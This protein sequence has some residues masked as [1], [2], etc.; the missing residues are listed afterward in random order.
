M[1][2]AVFFLIMLVDSFYAAEEVSS[3]TLGV[4]RFGTRLSFYVY[5]DVR[6]NGYANTS[7]LLPNP[8]RPGGKA[9]RSRKSKKAN[10]SN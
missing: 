8:S 1:L 4:P 10:V 9:K 5:A 7:A 2:G 3:R 6:L